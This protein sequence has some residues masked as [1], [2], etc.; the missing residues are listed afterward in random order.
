MVSPD[1]EEDQGQ[2]PSEEH[3]QEE[4]DKVRVRKVS[5]WTNVEWKQK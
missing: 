2:A 3:H 1:L 5:K 4:Q